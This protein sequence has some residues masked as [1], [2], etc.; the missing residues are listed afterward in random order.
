MR[1]WLETLLVAA[2]VVVAV[3]CG[4][5]EVQAQPSSGTTFYSTAVAVT[6]VTG[7]TFQQVLVNSNNRRGCFVQNNNATDTIWVFF[8]NPFTLPTPSKTT[9]VQLTSGQSMNCNSG[10]YIAGDTLWMT[11]ANNNDTAVLIYQVGS[12]Q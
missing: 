11:G 3:A 10:P 8:Q 7:N 2:F 12:Q 9:S 4:G 6:I 1:A 5:N